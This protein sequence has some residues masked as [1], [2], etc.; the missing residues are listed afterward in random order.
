MFEVGGRMGKLAKVALVIVII[1][2]I[3]AIYG[4]IS[5]YVGVYEG[6]KEVESPPSRF[7]VLETKIVNHDGCYPSL[8]VRF[9]TTKYTLLSIKLFTENGTLA[10]EAFPTEGQTGV[11]LMLIPY[12]CYKNIFRPHTYTLKVFYG[13]RQIYSREIRVLGAKPEIRLL[14]ISVENMTWVGY[15]VESMKLLVKNVG[16]VPLYITNTNI[17]VY[18]DEKQCPL[19]TVEGNE[20]V[21]LPHT[22]KTIIISPSMC[23]AKKLKTKLTI[24]IEGYDTNYNVTFSVDLSK[25][26]QSSK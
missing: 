7:E 21:V 12:G 4:I 20:V 11:T 10:D 17:K 2:G 18:V 6:L 24:E 3:L 14:G 23:V 22:Q 8:Y 16:D 26:L 5:L 1:L 9:N 13:D 15:S 25:Y 19:A